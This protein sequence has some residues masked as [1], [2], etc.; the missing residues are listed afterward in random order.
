MKSIKKWFFFNPFNNTSI[1]AFN[2]LTNDVGVI[3]LNRSKKSENQFIEIIRD[4]IISCIQ[5]KIPFLI[6]SSMLLAVKY[7]ANGIFVDLNNEQAL[8]SKR[9]LIFK[10]KR[11]KLIVASVIHNYSEMNI[12]NSLGLDMAF[13]SPVF[14]TKTHRKMNPLSRFRFFDL[15]K[16]TKSNLY[17]LGGIDTKNFKKIKNK[18]LNGFGAINYFINNSH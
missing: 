17:A 14:K 18:F 8:N 13:I 2:K 15:C 9:R 3:F 6:N 11:K 1:I 12:F 7:N 5:K 4:F 10:K 16:K